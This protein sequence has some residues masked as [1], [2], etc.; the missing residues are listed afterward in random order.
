[1]FLVEH[2]EPGSA[3]AV[4]SLYYNQ[5]HGYPGPTHALYSTLYHDQCTG[6]GIPSLGKHHEL[7]QLRPGPT[8]AAASQPPHRQLHALHGK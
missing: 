5:H 3:V 6:R 1:M 8:A 2:N 7:L 4:A